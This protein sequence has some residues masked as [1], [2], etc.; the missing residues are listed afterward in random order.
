MAN[1]KPQT[2][3]C[4][5]DPRIARASDRVGYRYFFSHRYKNT[6][7]GAFVRGA[8]AVSLVPSARDYWQFI[9]PSS[10]GGIADDWYMVGKDLDWSIL[11]FHKELEE[12][13]RYATPEAAE[14]TPDFV[15]A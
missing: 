2:G 7:P 14:D 12:H 3:C 10:G 6:F 4:I 9:A 5:H 15:T 8:E 1:Q 11:E 13:G